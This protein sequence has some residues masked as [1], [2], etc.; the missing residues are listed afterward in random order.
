VL[1][2][3]PPRAA[4]NEFPIN[5]CQADRADFSTRA[6]EDYANRGMMWKRACA[7]EGR[8]LRGLVTANV[9]RAGRVE[10]GARSYFI[11]RAPE[12]THFSNLVW[13][14]ET[15]RRDCRYALQLWAGRP[16][17]RPVAIRNLVA[18]HDCPAPLAPQAFGWPTARTYNIEG[19][20]KIVQRVLCVGSRK[21]P[22]CSARSLNYIRTFRAQATVV[23]TSAPGVTI[24]QDNPFTSGAWVRGAQTVSYAALDNVGVGFARALVGGRLYSGAPRACN[25]AARVPCPNGTASI[26]VDT[27]KL[28]E[29]TQPLVV[30][31]FDAASNPGDSAPVWVRVDNTAPGAVQAAV[32]GG[33]DWRNSNDF[34]VS[35]VNP[36]ELDRA[37]IAAAHY[38]LCP[39]GGGDCT[40]GGRS[41]SG[42]DHLGDLAVPAAGEWQL[43]VWREDAAGNQQR[44]NASVPV[45][46]RYDPEPPQL[47]F[48]AADSSDPT[49]VS[50]AV[51][52]RVSGL[53]DGQIE[54]SREGSGQWQSL[55]T[56]AAGDRLRARIDDAQL[57]PGTYLL[58]AT[59]HDHATNQSSTDRYVDGRPAVVTLPLR[60]P[61]RVRA[62][63]VTRQAFRRT[64]G[65]GRNR[66]RVRRRR[67]VLERQSRVPFG[68]VARIAGEVIARDGAPI[69]GAELRVLSFGT[70]S[71][72]QLVGTVRSDDHGRFSYDARGS[73]TQ[74]LRFYYGGTVLTLPAQ[75]DVRLEVPAASSIGRNTRRVRNGHAVTFTG[76]VRSRPT[77]PAGKLVELQ[78]QLSGRW[79]TFRTVR[80]KQDGSW[81]VRYR[82][83]RSCGLVRFRFRGR[84][85]AE[86]GYAFVTGHTRPVSVVVR[87]PRCR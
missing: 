80:T 84:L 49:A 48:E 13:S 54:L 14:G 50:V 15:R 33:E 4:A 57:A 78:V 60:R 68:G 75:R 37:P 17:A 63:I 58:R 56:N 62:G 42:I 73:S 77:P 51:T 87:G 53:A 24:T 69:A 82:F 9:V 67:T 55:P 25:Y 40:E 74:T 1:L 16:N 11:L 38:T 30:R 65:R 44:D 22:Y 26:P 72:E 83:R 31:A 6:F 19:A 20:T 61:T 39:A 64:V 43:R 66:H 18:N 21:R 2:L 23:D 10:R 70:T 81:R 27:T 3:G 76:E 12:G 85:P 36:F 28:D 8:G 59:A 41:E 71:T 32:A 45:T 79:Q 35:W 47:A 5:A 29:G 86:S 52:D 7:P 46:L 34:D